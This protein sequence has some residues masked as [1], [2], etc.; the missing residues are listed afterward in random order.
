[1]ADR[2]AASTVLI[3]GGGTGGHLIPAL[4]IGEAI[5][6]RHPECRVVL[7]GAR[8]GLE[9]TLLPERQFPYHLLPFEPIYRRQWWK[10]VR[11]PVLA[12]RL[13]RDVAR[14]LDDLRPAVVI[15]TGGYAS[16]P[17][18]WMAARRGI[19]TGVLE[20]NAYP[21][22]AVR[23]LARR[24]DD[25]WL[26]SPEARSHLRPAP[27]TRVVDTGTPI[28]AP[29]LSIRDA[30]RATFGL[31]PDKPVVLVSGGSQ[32]A[33]ALNQVVAR[34]V[35]TG[36]ANRRQ[37]LWVTGRGSYPEFQRFHDPPGVRVIDFLD[38]MR[39]GYAV[40]DVAI[41][42]AGMMTIAELSAWGIPSILIPLPTAAGDHQTANAKA[43]E[44]AGASIFLSQA[45]L[46]SE[47]LERTL[48]S[49]LDHPDRAASM[50][51]AALSRA[52]PDS[53]SR[54]LDRFGILSG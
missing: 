6:K 13:L 29:D 49:V 54:I 44:A 33:R 35:G 3:A 14:L 7:V 51:A 17:V 38:P 48:S 34:W 47:S 42:R 27:R 46:G 31:V 12:V 50:R 5:Q 40:A 21:G 26:G 39:L 30:A 25:I 45:D 10:N 36:M 18:V 4:V 9:A 16:G 22:L 11:W 37:L 2:D 32:G 15:G 28:A 23:R 53:L 20:L 43:M 8:R 52:R 24:V 41:A 19:P 1:L